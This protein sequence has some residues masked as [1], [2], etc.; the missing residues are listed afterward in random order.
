MSVVVDTSVWSLVLRRGTPTS[1][2]Q[3]QKLTSILRQGQPVALLG[4]VLQEILQ[5]IRDPSNF[6]RVKQHLDAF[7]LLNLERQD[8]VLAA[9][10]GNLCRSRGVQAS[11]VDFQIAAACIQ[12]GFGLLTCD[13]DFRHIAE[14]SPLQ[15]L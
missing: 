14:Y 15:I 11:T 9:E 6:E 7:P 4:V 10:L 12:N 2:P 3:V 13:Q 8:Y 1:D 5:G